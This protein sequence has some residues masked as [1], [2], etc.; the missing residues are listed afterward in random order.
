[1]NRTL[2]LFL[3]LF[4][5]Y[6]SY[7]QSASS[8]GSLNKGRTDH[9]S[10]LLPNGNVI[11]FG[12]NNHDVQNFQRLSSAEIYNPVT[13]VWELTDHLQTERDNFT[14]VLLNDGN[15]L[16]IGG[17]NQKEEPLA[18]CELYNLT[19][20]KWQATGKM[21]TPRAQHLSAKLN[22]GKIL[23]AGGLLGKTTEIFD[24]VTNTWSYVGE[25][26]VEHGG[27]MSLTLLDNGKVFALGGTLNPSKAEIFDPATSE[28]TLLS[29][30]T[31]QTY[32]FHSVIKLTSG[33]LLIVGS[34]SS[35]ATENLNSVLYDP[36]GNYFS[37][38]GNLVTPVG[39]VSMVLLDDGKVM[40]YSIGDFFSP[41]DTKCIQVYDPN[42]GKWTV[43]PYSFI[44]NNSSTAHLLH[45]GKVLFIGGQWTTG[46]GASNSCLLV[47]QNFN[48]ECSPPNLNLL[49][50]GSK[51]CNGNQAS[52]T[53][54]ISESGI[55]YEAY[56]GDTRLT[57]SLG[58]SGGESITLFLHQSFLAPGKNVIKIKAIKYG[59]PNRAYYQSYFLKDTAIVDVQIPAVFKPIIKAN[60]PTVFCQ[61]EKVELQGPS[62][63][64]G[65]LWSTG[66]TSEKITVT[67]AGFYRLRIK[68]ASGCFSDYSAPIKVSTT[69]ANAGIA[70]SF[71][72]NQSA[73]TLTGFSPLGGTWSGP[74]VSADGVL[75]PA[76]AGEGQ[77]TLKYTVCGLSATKSI[78]VLPK[79]KAPDFNFYVKNDNVCYNESTGVTV[80]NHKGGKFD[81]WKGGKFYHSFSSYSIYGSGFDTGPITEDTQFLIKSISSTECG[82]DTLTKSFTIH[83]VTKLNLTVGTSTPFV[84]KKS[85]GEVYII[86]SQLGF[87]YQMKVGNKPMGLPKAGNNDTLFFAT[88]PLLQTTTFSFEITN[89]YCPTTLQQTATIEVSGPSAHFTVST[90]NPE[91]GEEVK[92]I[93]T[94]HNDGK[95]YQWTFGPN[96]SSKGSS[97]ENP[98]SLV[99]DKVGS[100]FIKLVCTGAEGCQDSLLIKINVIPKVEENTINQTI[101]ASTS[102]VYAIATTKDAAGNNYTL[103]QGF[104]KVYNYSHSGD[105]LHVDHPYFDAFHEASFGYVKFQLVK[106]NIKGTIVWANTIY[107]QSEIGS[108]EL[109]VDSLGNIY[110][111]YF[112]SDYIDSV[113][114]V[115]TDGSITS[116]KPPHD[117]SNNTAVVILKYD[118]IG[119]LQWHSSYLESYLN[120]RTR[121]TLDK[122]LNIYVSS[123]SKLYKFDQNG[124]SQWMVN[125][126]YNDD[127]YTDL[128]IDSKG[129][130]L[131]LRHKQ[132]KV[133][134]YNNAGQLI[135]STQEPVSAG[136]SFQMVPAQL[137]I[138]ALDNLYISGIFSGDFIFNNQHF[139]SATNSTYDKKDVFLLKLNKQGAQIWAKHFRSSATVALRG[140]DLREDK[141]VFIGQGRSGSTIYYNNTSAPGVFLKEI[142]FNQEGIYIGVTDTTQTGEIKLGKIE[143]NEPTSNIYRYSSSV[144]FFKNSIKAK[145][146]FH[147]LG[148]SATIMGKNISIIPLYDSQL[149]EEIIR[150]EQTSFINFELPLDYLII[151]TPP[152]AQFSLSGSLC[153]GSPIA[154]TDNSLPF[155]TSWNWSFPGGNPSSSTVQNPIVIYETP[156]TYSV[157]LT[158]SN[159]L[160]TGTPTTQLIRLNNP[161]K[162]TLA[163]FSSICLGQPNVFL[164][165]GLPLGGTYSGPGVIDGTFHT[166]IAGLGTHKI[167]YTYT[168]ATGCQQKADRD[169]VVSVCTGIEDEV[170][171]RSGISI[172]P[173]PTS[174]KLIL[175]FDLVKNQAFE[176]SVYDATGK[177]VIQ[178]RASFYPDGRKE[179]N[180]GHL[181]KGIYHLQVIT[182]DKK[183]I[184]K[185]IVVQ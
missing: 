120:D 49:V 72:V 22:D 180:L 66:Q 179:I 130:V 177:V 178:K 53:M 140:F 185:N 132:L 128:K 149:P 10:Q 6:L 37:S 48:P 11:A 139:K 14:S 87:Q 39:K 17:M 94:S 5:T 79:P 176:Y 127:G 159:T 160:G 21:G 31:P 73:I 124:T 121:I 126:G 85:E 46:N 88:G 91:I 13:K 152:V 168:D 16:A 123:F 111:A 43:Q 150:E 101:S 59:C 81:I 181:A 95:V 134:T 65:Y 26:A 136:A 107:T 131:G 114:V 45:D 96:A 41:T 77:H 61:G 100:S 108:A 36:S 158:V 15:V 110:I 44:G 84:C 103:L 122:D 175:E 118:K 155:A 67:T 83:V 78:S 92:I 35:K 90:Y 119:L 153:L 60:G 40:L 33:N 184:Q 12:G 47:N 29:V 93:N 133:D 74:G 56:V 64:S 70:E 52:I 97:L 169:L 166:E 1:M 182:K 24:P 183:T 137:R 69:L 50:N 4:T 76:L 25:M 2:L 164:T 38:T 8:T 54:P 157:T 30:F 117:G 116:F 161:P 156:G 28:W 145:L 62:G 167:T 42:T 7:A 82:S 154:F 27:G 173:N 125:L 142:R 55:Y 163:P 75:T 141:L 162:V 51:G 171:I 98:P 143:T 104:T 174:G 23:V 63:M 89:T 32:L 146:G 57:N 68:D 147:L 148:K 170:G 144:S 18:S 129:N 58:Y 34:Q 138:D 20:G 172:Y 135:A 115:S 99:F 113:N 9:E 86:K 106:Y 19:T 102:P 71:C 112:H 3:Y 80:Y 105:S 165:G 151:A 109:K